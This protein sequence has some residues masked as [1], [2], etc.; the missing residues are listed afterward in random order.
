MLEKLPRFA[1]PRELSLNTTALPEVS[2]IEQVVLSG[3]DSATQVH[4]SLGAKGSVERCI[5]YA[6]EMTLEVD[7]QCEEL[8]LDAFRMAGLDGVVYPLQGTSIMKKQIWMKVSPE[9]AE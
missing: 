2:F 7:Y 6:G 4:N 3:L 9:L 8:M 5:N 1:I